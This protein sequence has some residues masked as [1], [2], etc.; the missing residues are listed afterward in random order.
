[1][2]ELPQIVRERLKASPSPGIHPD[3]DVLTAFGEQLLPE[4]ERA[5]VLDHLSRCGD[6]REVI[7]L[8]L[9]VSEAADV[10]AA[11]TVQRG[12]FGWPSLRWA[13]VAAGIVAAVSVGVQQFWVHRQAN[14]SV[15]HVMT[16]SQDRNAAAPT[17]APQSQPFAPPTPPR[18]EGK[19]KSPDA[20]ISNKSATTHETKDFFQP[21]RTG[22][23]DSAG[24]VV[25]SGAASD[26]SARP[27]SKIAMAEPPRD[28]PF[29]PDSR[30]SMSPAVAKRAPAPAPSPAEPPSVAGTVEVQG[31]SSQTAAQ[32]GSP[33]PEQALQSRNAGEPQLS[34]G[35]ADVVERAKSPVAPPGTPAAAP[36]STARW[37]ISSTGSLQRSL[38]GGNSW[39]EIEVATKAAPVGNFLTV[40]SVAKSQADIAD[41]ETRRTEDKK[42]QTQTPANPVFR[43]VAAAGLDVWAGGSGSMLYHSRDGGEHWTRVLPSADGVV[44]K[45][46]ITSVQFPD[47][48][49]G[50]VSTSNSEVWTT[51][52]GGQSWRQQ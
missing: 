47:P 31:Q 4:S 14:V 25:A 2:P 39:Q 28:L 9:P 29:A 36:A 15:A 48:Q 5:L 3:A 43:T 46:D 19:L 33:S 11:R 38:D 42:S 7:A 32:S 49:H 10:A 21:S 1:M 40:E 22:R 16:P 35:R 44:L 23:A 41:K 51:S 20:V 30:K 6:C 52:D 8:A 18:E 27:Q 12:W 26:T 50:M 17:Q 45:G 34:A 13:F 37:T 24:A